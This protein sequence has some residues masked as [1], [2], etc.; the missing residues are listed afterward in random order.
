MEGMEISFECE[1]EL[2]YP[3]EWFKD[4][5]LLIPSS[6]LIIETLYSNVHKLTI[7]QTTPADTGTYCVKM[8]EKSSS[9][10][11]VVKGNSKL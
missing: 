4:D 7:L 9:A 5:D 2:S 10:D 8:N 6:R 1:A 11:L 3:V